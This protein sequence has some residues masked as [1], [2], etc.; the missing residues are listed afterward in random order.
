MMVVILT[1]PR[2]SD[3]IHFPSAEA[4]IEWQQEKTQ[5]PSSSSGSR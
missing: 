1:T 3:E 5:L 2:R 4:S